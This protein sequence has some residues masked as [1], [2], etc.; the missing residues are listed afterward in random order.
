[1]YRSSF[2]VMNNGGGASFSLQ[3]RLQAAAFANFANL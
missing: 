3:R 1:V 2:A